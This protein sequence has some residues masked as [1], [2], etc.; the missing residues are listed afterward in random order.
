MFVYLPKNLTYNHVRIQCMG[1]RFGQKIDQIH[2]YFSYFRTFDN[3]FSECDGS[4]LKI[5][6]ETNNYI[7]FPNNFKY[8]RVH[9]QCIG[10]RFG[11]KLGHNRTKLTKLWIFNYQFFKTFWPA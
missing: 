4:E 8:N 1:V 6:C 9:I 3:H 7:I 10:V 2:R 11:Q 5:S